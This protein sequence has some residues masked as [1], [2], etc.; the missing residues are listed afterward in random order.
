LRKRLLASLIVCVALLTQFGAS[1]LGATEARAGL[2]GCHE[3]VA[4]SSPAERSAEPRRVPAQTPVRHD[5]ASCYLCQLG[6][7]IVRSEAP[8]IETRVVAHH[9]VR[10]AEPQP[11]APITVLNYSAPAR[12]SP[13][14]A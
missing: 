2:I 3:S 12:A 1:L 10:L 7:S 11:P 5:H 8:N 9:R 6:F 4:W 14:P 13:F